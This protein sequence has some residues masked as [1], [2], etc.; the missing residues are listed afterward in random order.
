[1][2]LAIKKGFT[3]IELLSILVIIAIILV[4]AVPQV[5]MLIEK[6]RQETLLNQAR[7]Y[8]RTIGH[9]YQVSE[10][11]DDIIPLLGRCNDLEKI[12]FENGKCKYII[13]EETKET[14]IKIIGENQYDNIV[15]YG[16][17][18]ELKVY[19]TEEYEEEVPQI[20]ITGESSIEI[21]Y[22]QEYI[23]LG[24]TSDYE[25]EVINNVNTNEIGE[26]KVIYKVDSN[27]QKV[28]AIR[29]VT[30]ID[31]VAPVITIIGS[32]PIQIDLGSTYNDLGATALDDVD[33]DIS[34]QIQVTNNVNINSAGSYNVIYTVTDSSGN[35][36]TATR[37]V[38]VVI[39]I[40]AP[41]A[42]G[43]F[44]NNVAGLYK[45]SSNNI[46]WGNTTNWGNPN[47]GLN[48]RLEVQYNGG[49][50]TSVATTGTTSNR[51]HTISS[52]STNDTV[53]YR[54]RAENS[55]L[56]SDWVYSNVFKIF[57]W[58]LYTVGTSSYNSVYHYNG[59][60]VAVGWE[61][62]IATSTDSRNWTTLNIR[63]DP[64]RKVYN[65]GGRWLAIGD[66]GRISTSTN[67]TSWSPQQVGTNRYWDVYNYN[68][69]WV[70]VGESG[71]ISTSTNGTSWSTQQVGTNTYYSI[72]NYNGRW[73]AVGATGR[74]STSTNGT[75]WSTQQLG[76]NTY[77]SVYNHNGRWVAV[78]TNGIVS[79][80]TNGT[81]WSSQTLG[82]DTYWNVYYHDGSWVATGA[83]GNI[84]NSTSGTSWSH[85]IYPDKIFFGR[86][87]HA[88]NGNWITAV[89]QDA[90]IST[91]GGTTWT[92][93]NILGANSK[94][95]IYYGDGVWIA[96]G[97]G[98]QIS[99]GV[100]D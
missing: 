96:V 57:G 21:G 11:E 97:A 37:V 83:Y 39:P 29:D 88:A 55:S 19:T 44:T 84:A 38:N 7:L 95:D 14:T 85:Q 25:I 22:Q 52:A 93:F 47:T 90:Y 49:T 54:V 61:G 73:V 16:T 78:G 67:G 13:E 79:T 23:D 5:L 27:S 24:A 42:P 89:R 63:T 15:V 8:I 64:Y 3:L 94:R 2:K 48:Y 6:S 53:R 41:N 35:V 80:S 98:G 43:A 77:N 72:Y 10:I 66:N 92:E 71:T 30:V 50:W 26:Y 20:E 87:L 86:L 36:S 76:T 75:S 33:G 17:E 56:Q 70:M 40:T 60:W 74:I 4:I 99:R 82:T 81:S 62:I 9:E 46:N 1:M 69:R 18:E 45:G 65:Y 32:N 58:T 28:I 51:N 34:S 68:G 100:I 12:N 91:N 59:R 31:T